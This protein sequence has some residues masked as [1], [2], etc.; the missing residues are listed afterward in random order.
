[1][2]LKGICIWFDGNNGLMYVTSIVMII[3]DSKNIIP[4]R[5]VLFIITRIN[6]MIIKLM[7]SEMVVIIITIKSLCVFLWKFLKYSKINL[8]IS[9]NKPEVVN[10]QIIAKLKKSNR[11]WVYFIFQNG[12]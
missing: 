11:I 3:I 10:A 8:S 9:F 5:L 6:P 1:M 2:D 12:L 4:K 7:V